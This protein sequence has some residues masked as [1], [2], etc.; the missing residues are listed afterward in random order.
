MTSTG[1]PY[2]NWRLLFE[3]GE[4]LRVDPS[5]TALLVID[6]QYYDAHPDFGMGRDARALGKAD[7]F[8]YYWQQVREIVPRISQLCRLARAASVRVIFSRIAALTESC[9]D[10]GL[11][12]RLCNIR[13]PI[14]SKEA[15]I[16]PELMPGSGDIVLSK[17]SSSVVQLD[18]DKPDSSQ[19]SRR[20][21]G[22]LRCRN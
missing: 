15:E 9:D 4:R 2:N 13:V 10:I 3:Q 19:S 20:N 8:D 11:L 16:L 17:S 5:R 18:S 1:L 14:N 22:Y 21:A 7:V 12:Y 6:V